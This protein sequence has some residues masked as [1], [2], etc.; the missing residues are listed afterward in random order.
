MAAVDDQK[1]AAETV[2]GGRAEGGGGAGVG[3]C[4]KVGAQKRGDNQTAQG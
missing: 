3:G 4:V 2:G 1:R